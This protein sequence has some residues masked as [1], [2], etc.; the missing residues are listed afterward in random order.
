MRDEN[1]FLP[2]TLV[3]VAVDALNSDVMHMS[4]MQ[5]L[6]A[7]FDALRDGEQRRL[8]REMH[9]DFGQLLAAMKVDLALL[10][11]DAGRTG[12]PPCKH[13]VS[14]NELVDT[15]LI[16]VRRII[17]D[18]PPLAIEEHGLFGALEQL[19]CNFRKRHS[20][21][22]GLQLSAS[23]H[24][25]SDGL[26]RS[27]YRIIQEALHNI[28]RH[29]NARHASIRLRQA[30][31]NLVIEIED[32]GQGAS[33]AQLLKNG[34]YGLTSMQERVTALDGTM[35]FCSDKGNGT[36]IQAVLPL[37]ASQSLNQP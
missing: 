27:V 22:I 18:L 14:L 5:V 2:L 6:I 37:G 25:L 3:P 12:Q 28:V 11:R 9:D 19:A 36:R 1:G 23:A 34:S 16:S 31:G 32:D 15:M 7:A 35:T 29:A 21:E 13:L 24:G 26:E 10:Q 33:S 17:A 20:I 4:P 8:T 30:G